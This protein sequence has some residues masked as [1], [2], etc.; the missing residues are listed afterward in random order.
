MDNGAKVIVNADGTVST[1]IGNASST[2]G[3]TQTFSG[4]NANWM[5]AAYDPVAN[6][7]VIAYQDAANSSRGTATVGTITGTTIS[8]G[9]AVVFETGDTRY[10]SIAYV[11]GVQKFVIAYMDAGNNFFGTAV[12]G[13][14]SGT[15]I[16]FGTPV[17]FNS[18]QTDDISVAAK[19]TG[20]AN[21]VAIAYRSRGASD[22]GIV[23]TALVNSNSTLTFGSPVTF[24]ANGGG[25]DAITATYH[26]QQD[27]LVITF[28]RYGSPP[29]NNRNWA[30]VG[31]L[32]GSGATGTVT[33]G[34]PVQFT[35][36]YCDFVSACYDANSFRVVVAYREIGSTLSGFAI[37]ATVS[38]LTI[39]FGTAVLFETGDTRETSATFN[40]AANRVVIAYYD[41]GNSDRATYVIGTVSGT[42]IAFGSPVVNNTSAVDYTAVT[43]T[44]NGTNRNVVLVTADGSGRAYVLPMAWTLLTAENYI[45]ISAGDYSN[46]GTATIQIVGSVD[47]AQ[48]GL[49][50]GQSYFVQ[51]DG[52]LGL[53]AGSPSVFAGTAV[54]ANRIIVKG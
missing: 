23:R 52:T 35:N 1:V 32:S 12:V 40:I 25:G 4:S 36:T 17:V 49:T 14:V 10:I 6:R 44:D 5:A 21:T 34:T 30:V 19:T 22:S 13:T 41:Q 31:S 28:L 20:T 48:T 39:S 37:V 7:V 47:D 38:D 42:A 9:T 29:T 53:T 8:F 46:G 51:T 26:T 43:Y 11:P 2:I 18:V 33:F 27:R 16:S 50:A 45:G 3:A 15:A 24:E 54:A